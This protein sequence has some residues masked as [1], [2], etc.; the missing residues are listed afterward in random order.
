MITPIPRL[1]HEHLGWI[2]RQYNEGFEELQTRDHPP[3]ER[4]IASKSK[5]SKIL[6]SD[7]MSRMFRLKFLWFAQ[8]QT[9]YILAKSHSD[10]LITPPQVSENWTRRYLDCN[11]QFYKKKQKPLAIERKNA[12]NEDNFKDYFVKYKGIR[13]DKGITDE[14]TLNMDE[15]E[16]RAGCGRAHWIITLGPDKPLLLTAPDNRKY[17]T[18]VESI[19]GGGKAIPPMLILC[20]ILILEKWAEEMILMK[21]FC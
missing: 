21:T 5:Q 7:S 13:I 20:G 11:P 6:L 16:F 15:T 19:S 1:R 12:H 4:Y 10:P 18:S 8:P 14:D 9:T 17:I 2:R 3:T